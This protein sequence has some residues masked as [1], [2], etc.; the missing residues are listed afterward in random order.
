MSK[1]DTLVNSI[2]RTGTAAFAGALITYLIAH[3]FNIDSSI[4]DVVAGLLFTVVSTGYYTVSRV[5]EHY[6]S[7]HFGWLLLSAGRPSYP[8]VKTVSKEEA[9]ADKE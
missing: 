5:L 1:F 9:E 8:S 3:G 6:V 4:K 7:E 2:I